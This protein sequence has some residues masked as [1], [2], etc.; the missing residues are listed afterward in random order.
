MADSNT[1]NLSYPSQLAIFLGLTG[2]A[3]VIASLASLAI[4]MMMTGIP[5]PT[6]T[7]DLLQP[8]FYKVNMVMQAVSTFL[9]F[10]IPVHFFAL[11]CYKKPYEFLGFN[12]RFNY[13]QFFLVI[14][15]LILTFPLSGALAELNKILPIPQDWALKFKAM[16][17]AR[18]AQEAALIHIDSLAKFFISLF[19]IA[20]LP[21]IFEETFFR[22]GLQ[23][24]LTRWF[25]GPWVAIIFT[26]LIFSLIHLSYY[27]F[28]VRF[29][30]GIILGFIFYYS[31]SLW[32]SILLHF[33]FNGVQ[34]IALYVI[35]I[36]GVKDKK[37][38]ETSFPLWAG[39]LALLALVYL[40]KLYKRTSQ[41]EISKYTIPA[42][43]ENDPENWITKS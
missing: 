9:I 10:F 42:V 33:L 23:N 12:F 2:G 3:V 27:G 7:A 6:K 25:K 43:D 13:K 37:D 20:L 14:G 24:F 28:I 8:Q 11:I 36:T 30:L 17:L 19:V 32:L 16:E 39:C 34:V 18:Q 21:A 22:G 4:W 35:T 40:F 38:L 31:K 15:I 41:I 5:F 1:R 26:S 29:S